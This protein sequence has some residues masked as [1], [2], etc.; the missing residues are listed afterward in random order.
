[1]SIQANILTKK[2][3]ETIVK[4][5]LSKELSVVYS[6]L[7]KLREQNTDINDII[8]VLSRSKL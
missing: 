5:K 7:Q 1:M 4:E 3:I 2:E 8:K 6:Q